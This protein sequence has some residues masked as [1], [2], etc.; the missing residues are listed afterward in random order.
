MRCLNLLAITTALALSACGPGESQKQKFAEQKRIECMDKFCDG[1]IEP[2]RNMTTEAALKL[3]G[4]W[5]IAPK[6]YYST[7][8]NGGGFYW[9]SRHPMFKGGDYPEGR[10]EFPEKAIEIFL[11]GR[12]RWPEPNAVEPWKRESQ[13]EIR[14]RELQAKGY[15]I[16]RSRPNP[17]LEIVRVFDSQ[18]NANDGIYY[19]AIQQKEGLADR[20]SGIR[21]DLPRPSG[22]ESCAGGSFWQPN[23][24]ADYRFSAKH[25]HD[26]PAISNEITRVLSLLKK[27]QP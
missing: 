10:Q 5:Y 8:K 23:V 18:G 4:Q 9:P 26:W 14:W 21:C 1:D 25:A 16:E 3:H 12:Q 2:L 19:I 20:H 27:A 7:G 6:H 13:F 22:K 17:E 15:R 24:F 11:T